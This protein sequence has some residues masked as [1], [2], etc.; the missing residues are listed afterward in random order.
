MSKK[1][2]FKTVGFIGFVLSMIAALLS[3]S[4]DDKKMEDEIEKQV[5][6]ALAA[7]QD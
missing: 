4:A 2:N 6:K 7:H 5:A 3:K 1:I